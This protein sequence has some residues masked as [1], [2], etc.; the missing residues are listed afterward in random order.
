M[1]SKPKQ[2]RKWWIRGLAAFAFAVTLHGLL[3]WLIAGWLGLR[4]LRNFRVIEVSF[5][6]AGLKTSIEAEQPKRQ[7]LPIAKVTKKGTGP[8]EAGSASPINESAQTPAP[9]P[10]DGTIDSDGAQ[11][12]R[13]TQAY[14]NES[15]RLLKAFFAEVQT[16]TVLPAGQYVLV[17]HPDRD[18]RIRSAFL[19]NSSGENTSAREIESA[20]E[21]SVQLPPLPTAIA[22]QDLRLRVPLVLD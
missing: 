5:H 8:P 6:D 19:E 17:I 18:G 9:Q 7:E 13:E 14:V 16:A 20:V 2:S 4:P 3:A 1:N 21:Q 22:D 15:S 11:G 12:R 10:L